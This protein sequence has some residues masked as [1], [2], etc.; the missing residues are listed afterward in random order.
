[1]R[2][3]TDDEALFCGAHFAHIRAYYERAR[4]A[5]IAED[6]RRAIPSRLRGLKHFK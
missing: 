6:C 1:M 4:L 5:R 2:H 3:M